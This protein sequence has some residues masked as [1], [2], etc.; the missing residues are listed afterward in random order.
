MMLIGDNPQELME[1]LMQYYMTH[2]GM[3]VSRAAIAMR[4]DLRTVVD[5]RK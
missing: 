5:D 2:Y 1:R 4:H 3:T